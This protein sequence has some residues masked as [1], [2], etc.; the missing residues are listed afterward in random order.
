MQKIIQGVHTF[1]QTSFR[2]R[3]HHPA[4]DDRKE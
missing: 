3:G 4:W 2:G 1:Q